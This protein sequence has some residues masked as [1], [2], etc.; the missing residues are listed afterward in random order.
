MVQLPE[1]KPLPEIALVRRQFHFP[2]T[3]EIKYHKTK[4]RHRDE[5]FRAIQPIPFRVRAVVVS[6]VSLAK[7]FKNTKG[8]ALLIDFFAR[9]LM[10][11]SPLDIAKDILIV[12]GT[13]PIFRQTLR[14]RISDECRKSHRVQPFSKIISGDSKREDGLQLADMIIGAIR[15]HITQGDSQYF[16]TF[17]DKVVDLWQVV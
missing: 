15:N 8:D 3:F 11:A 9:L 5:F 16:R 6:K 1:R 10:R 2:P 13:T 12:D 14:I 17:S 7:V 4:A